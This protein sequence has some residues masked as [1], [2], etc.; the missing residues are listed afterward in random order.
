MTTPSLALLL[1]ILIPSAG[2]LLF[3]NKSF[4]ADLKR[5]IC[6]TVLLICTLLS[7]LPVA[8]GNAGKELVLFRLTSTLPVLL[9]ADLVGLFFAF[10]IAFIWLAAGVYSFE[11]MQHEENRTRFYVFYLLTLASLMALCFA[12]TLPTYYM[13]YELMTLLS[14]PMVMHTMQKDAVAGG[15]KYLVYSVTGATLVLLGLFIIAPHVDSLVFVPGGHIAEATPVILV[16]AMLMIIGFGTKAG[17]FPLHGW[18]PSAHP[19]APSPAS[20]VLSGIITKAGVLGIFRVI[21]CLI[22]ADV[23]RGTWVHTVFMS[24]CLF[25]VF[26]GSLLALRE[27]SLKKRLAYSSVSQ[28][29]YV[30]TGLATMNPIG[31]L[32]ALL[33]VAAHALIKNTLF[34]TAGAVIYK[35]HRTKVSELEGLGKQMPVTFICFTIAALG[36]IGIP[37]CLGFVSK[38]Y[39]AQGAL[40]AVVTHDFLTWLAPCVLLLSALMTAGYLMTIAIRAFF[41]VNR[42]NAVATTDKN[43]PTAMMLVP[44]ILLATLMVILGVF[45]GALTKL[46]ETIA[47]TV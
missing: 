15:I 37:P 45:P 33:H 47:L 19:V 40:E 34:M 9:K 3:L 27:G 36:L 32:G 1:P 38:W 28:V 30:L 17:M 8:F 6:T 21:Y 42:Q 29:S 22:G 13:F 14:V 44:M 7:L 46:I 10:L 31:V 43:D 39:L 35:T 18:L 4:R 41:P 23:L 16:A 11:Y 2:T 12:A 26:M 24:L 25:T 20:A 5:N